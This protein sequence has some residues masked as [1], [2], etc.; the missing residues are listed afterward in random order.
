[1]PVPI[2]TNDVDS[3]IDPWTAALHAR[4][5]L[6]SDPNNPGAWGAMA[7]AQALLGNYGAAIK[8]YRAARDLAP[9]NPWFSHNIGH[10]L[11]VAMN[12][13]EE[14]LPFLLFAENLLPGEPDIVTSLAH[15][16]GRCGALEEA[17]RVLATANAR[18][19]SPEHVALRQ[20]LENGARDAEPYE[21][22]AGVT[23][24]SKLAP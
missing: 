24:R 23:K 17:S 19:D 4:R 12:Q 5:L 6:A 20:W 18:Q 2:P 7:L 10:L 15:A 11:D 21:R 3:E 1:M 13:P 22:A 16:L 8:G 14:A 9:D